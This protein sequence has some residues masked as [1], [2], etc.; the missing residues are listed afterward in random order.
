MTGIATMTEEPAA[1]QGARRERL[2][3]RRK[4]LGLTQ[5]ALAAVMGVDRSTVGRWERGDSE[6]LPSIRPKL[7]HALR[8]SA[9]RLEVLLAADGEDAAVLLPVSA[10]GTGTAPAVPRQLPSAVAGFTG[11]AQELAELTRLMDQAAAGPGTVVISAIGGTAGVGKTALALHWAHRVADRFA[12]GQLYAN[13]RGFDPSGVPA[14]PEETVRG[15]LNALGV[16]P[17]RVPPGP[18]AQAALY[19]GV[20]ADKRVLIVLDNARDEEQVRPLLAA[21]PGSLVL[22]TSRNQLAGLAAANGARLLGL[23]VLA[24]A[25]AVQL[26]TARLGGTRAAAEPG[27]VGEIADRCAGLPLALT[28][29][30]ARA[31]TRPHFPLAALAPE[32]RGLAGRLDALDSGDPTISVRTVFSWSYRQLAADAARMFRLLGLHPGPD[33]SVPAAAS[34]TGYPLP[35]AR[36]LLGE[37]ARACLITEHVPGRYVFHDLLLAYAAS[38]AS[39]ID[40][41]PERGAATG[42]LLDHYLHTAAGAANALNMSGEAIVLDAPG[43]GVAPEQLTSHRQARA[44]FAAEHRVLLAAVTLAAESGFD[45]HAWQLPWAMASYQAPDDYPERER[46]SPRHPWNLK[47]QRR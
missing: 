18:E 25:E 44:W 1:G 41:G 15:F 9:D 42:R 4:S 29:A 2:A 16:P 14:A 11:R 36:R 47:I 30:A 5:E 27:A 20:L 32:L 19:R 6:P 39:D 3:K 26:L 23:D 35:Q 45:R 31:A 38:Q 34:M 28:V 24:R 12:D 13:L 46:V 7:A 43:P 37:L 40:T 10:R 33:I 21:S 17:E 22:V 8:V